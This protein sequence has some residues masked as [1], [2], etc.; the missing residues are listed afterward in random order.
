MEYG[1]I[2]QYKGPFSAGASFSL[3]KSTKFG[4]SINEKDYMK[5]DGQGK[6]LA[7]IID[8]QQI[9]LGE[10][11]MYETDNAIASGSIIQFPEGAPA[12]TLINIVYDEEEEE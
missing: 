4:I 10:T 12:S 7:F 2:L 1:T 6:K 5:L 11:F 8:G 9:H 3:E